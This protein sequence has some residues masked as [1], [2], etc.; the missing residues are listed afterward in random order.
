MRVDGPEG[1][2]GGEVCKGY[3]G[4]L[5]VLEFGRWRAVP[6]DPGVA[7]RVFAGCCWAGCFAVQRRD[8]CFWPDIR[9][10]T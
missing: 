2:H 3:S 10:P 6:D 1:F 9:V 7:E 8:G 5:V 4:F